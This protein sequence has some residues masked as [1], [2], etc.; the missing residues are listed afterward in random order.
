MIGFAFAGVVLDQV[1]HFAVFKQVT[2]LFILVPVILNLKS[3]L[4]LN[5]AS[6]LSEAANS[7]TLSF[8]LVMGN[9]ALVQLQALLAAFASGLWVYILGGIINGGHFESE[10]GTSLVV[11]VSLITASLASLASSILMSIIVAVCKQIGIDPDNIATPLAAS[12]GDLFTLVIMSAASVILGQFLSTNLPLI[13]GIIF[14]M[15]IPICWWLVS[16]NEFARPHIEKGWGAIFLGMAIATGAGIALERAIKRFPGL[17]LV[18]PVLTG[19]AGC[20]GAIH[21]SRWATRLLILA[22]E[23]LQATATTL[24]AISIPVHWIFLLIIA[25]LNMAKTVKDPAEYAL[26]FF[27]MYTLVA[28]FA[29]A[30]VLWLA[31]VLT[32]Y[33]FRKGWSASSALPVIAALADLLGTGLL[34]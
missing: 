20:V 5:L 27:V 14:L 29:T 7:D 28:A 22:K 12:T 33:C 24:F 31:G 19:L 15:P 25:F 17:A 8:R 18:T 3:S 6:R 23:A 1:Q 34:I 26:I 16:N 30:C 32:R 9:I 4:E 10:K 2:E 21:A 11:S 13:A